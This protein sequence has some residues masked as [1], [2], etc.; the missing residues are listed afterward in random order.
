MIQTQ[1]TRTLALA[2]LVPAGKPEYPSDQL[3]LSSRHI[4]LMK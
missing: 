2:G 1:V 4:H 3:H